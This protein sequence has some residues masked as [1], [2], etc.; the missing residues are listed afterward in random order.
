M[1]RKLQPEKFENRSNTEQGSLNK[2]KKK[3]KKKKKKSYHS[4]Q[5]LS[6]MFL[7]MYDDDDRNEASSLSSSQ[8]QGEAASLLDSIDD[9][10]TP[11]EDSTIEGAEEAKPERKKPSKKRSKSDDEE[12]EEK[13]I[14]YPLVIALFLQNGDYFQG[15]YPLHTTSTGQIKIAQPISEVASSSNING[16]D[17]SSSSSSA[18]SSLS[19]ASPKLLSQAESK[20]SEETVGSGEGREK[21][22]LLGLDLAESEPDAPNPITVNPLLQLLCSPTSSL[23][24]KVSYILLLMH[25]TKRS[26][27]N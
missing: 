16:G 13:N 3:S 4:D 1:L 27:R 20:L 11:G 24:L 14:S 2:K 25:I 18:S 7:D 22:L 17:L 26:V 21:C 9:S 19:F 15:N 6:S 8:I 12:E 10:S 5:S 23:V